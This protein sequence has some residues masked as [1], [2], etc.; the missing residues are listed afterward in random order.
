M[1]LV[2][3]KAEELL[4]RISSDHG[5]GSVNCERLEPKDGSKFGGKSCKYEMKAVEMV[6]EIGI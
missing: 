1:I 4:T 3:C 5:L 2:A 6:I